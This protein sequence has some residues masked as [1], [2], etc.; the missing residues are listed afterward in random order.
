MPRAVALTIED[1]LPDCD[2]P[3]QFRVEAYGDG[4]NYAEGP[5]TSSWSMPVEAECGSP[6]PVELDPP[7]APSNLTAT[8][9]GQPCTA[10][11][12][13]WDARIGVAKYWVN[14]GINPPARVFRESLTA[15]NLAP[16]T[17]YSFA[18]RG[19]GDD[20]RYADEWGP[21]ST[22]SATTCIVPTPTPEPC[23]DSDCPTPTPAPTPTPPPSQQLKFPSTIKT[24]YYFPWN[25]DVSVLLDAATGGTGPITYD[26]SPTIGDGLTFYEE[27]RAISGKPKSTTGEIPYTY[28]ATD[29]S[30]AQ[31]SI[32]LNITILAIAFHLE[33]PDGPKSDMNPSIVDRHWRLLEWG[34]IRIKN[35]STIPINSDLLFRVRVPYATGLQMD[36][37][38]CRWLELKI[39]KVVSQWESVPDYGSEDDLWSPWQP[40]NMPIPVVRCGVGSGELEEIRLE[41]RMSQSMMGEVLFSHDE[42]ARRALHV[43]EDTVSY[44]IVDP[45][46]PAKPVGAFVDYLQT[47]EEGFNGF[48]SGVTHT[49]A[50]IWSGDSESDDIWGGQ[51]VPTTFSHISVEET[52]NVLIS[53]LWRDH[54]FEQECGAAYACVKPGTVGD[55]HNTGQ[56]Q[57]IVAFPPNAFEDQEGKIVFGYWTDNVELAMEMPNE[58][59]YLPAVM[60]HEFGH[61]LGL[62]H[63]SPVLK[64]TGAHSV[65]V[66][67]LTL[68]TTPKPYDT[69]GLSYLYDVHSH[70]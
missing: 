34:L 68:L 35:N 33:R 18:V 50:E 3:Y 4:I 67:G 10:I 5:T 20:I 56:Q 27:A 8:P 66:A 17:T 58:A 63:S 54:G 48:L 55:S 64:F 22:V 59:F 45:L 41:L 38:L 42:L 29:S 1:R 70:D 11:T 23:P 65:M 37:T 49:A 61:T 9:S 47:T 7:P 46:L 31:A 51:S 6:L 12:L 25:D 52:P 21:A 53:G 26:I 28:T 15:G 2:E 19:V 69:V 16:S 43:D 40:L 62:G 60:L 13:A 57:L 30:G 32:E 39:E 24:A 36:N 44:G 14:R